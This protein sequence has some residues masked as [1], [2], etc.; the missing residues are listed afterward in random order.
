MFKNFIA[1]FVGAWLLFV[2]V[3]L[4]AGA[5]S[6]ELYVKRENWVNTMIAA[7][8]A[9]RGSSLA[10]LE[11]QKAGDQ[12]WFRIKE[13]FPIE[14]DWVLQDG[15]ADFARWLDSDKAVGIAREITAKALVD[16]KDPGDAL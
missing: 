9:L 5:S 2:G 8:E 14:W 4:T 16:I 15:G 3:G 1:A 13:D 10:E 11:Q 12:I 7:R 6:A